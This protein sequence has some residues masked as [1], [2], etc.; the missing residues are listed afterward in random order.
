MTS[1][2]FDA[3]ASK[4]RPRRWRASPHTNRGGIA[5]H[6]ARLIWLTALFGRRERVTIAEYH[7]RFGVS[8]RSFRRDI[9]L[10]RE[11]GFYL[12]TT[13]LVTTGC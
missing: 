7:R 5:F 6:I 4:T 3:L 11:A 10:I 9:A 1:T 13:A 8:V 2:R 12:E